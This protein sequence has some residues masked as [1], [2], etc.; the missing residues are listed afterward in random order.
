MKIHL[1]HANITSHC[2]K[3]VRYDIREPLGNFQLLKQD[4]VL[5]VK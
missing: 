4:Q 3:E 1:A 2:Y 5:H